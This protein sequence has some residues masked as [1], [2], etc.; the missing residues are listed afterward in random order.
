METKLAELSKKFDEQL[1]AKDAEIA[2]LKE[3]APPKAADTKAP[4]E[5][6]RKEYAPAD[7][8]NVKAALEAFM[9]GDARTPVQVV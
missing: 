7:P 1:K 9:K 8:R 4:A 5:L 6:K 3:P 2:K